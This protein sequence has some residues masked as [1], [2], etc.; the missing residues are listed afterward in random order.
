MG[1]VE[2]NLMPDEQIVYTGHVHSFS[3]LPGFAVMVF[4]A[5]VATA[6]GSHPD[7]PRPMTM[8]FLLGGGMAFLW[9]L[10]HFLA[11]LVRK[12]TTEIALTTRR[13][14]AKSGIVV[15]EITELNY[16]RVESFTVDQPLLGMIF[17]YGTFFIHGV[18]G[19]KAG[20]RCI[21]RP[22]EFRH[23]ALEMLDKTSNQRDP[24]AAA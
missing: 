8:F 20:I 9:G 21:A 10:Y 11:A 18:G 17:G 15:R 2:N 4:G 1:Y 12:S 24:K 22:M 13:I 6:P 14:I 5:V 19:S 3:M 7:F 23:K 16:S